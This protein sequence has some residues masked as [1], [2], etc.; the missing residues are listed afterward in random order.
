MW[1]PTL[2]SLLVSL[3]PIISLQ[4]LRFQY[5]PSKFEA[6]IRKPSEGFVTI[7][8]DE[9]DGTNHFYLGDRLFDFRGFK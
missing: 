5:P 3:P 2:A 8:Q 1:K 7:R 4:T 6:P 9:V